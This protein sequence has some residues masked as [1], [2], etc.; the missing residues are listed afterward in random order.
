MLHIRRQQAGGFLEAI[1]ERCYLGAARMRHQES[2]NGKRGFFKFFQ[3]ACSA[4]Q[5][6]FNFC[7]D[8]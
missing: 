6:S 7:N 5:S 2:C 4:S 1:H 8:L 3:W